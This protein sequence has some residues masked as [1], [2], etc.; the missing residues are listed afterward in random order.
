[1][2][3]TKNDSMKDKSYVFSGYKQRNNVCLVYLE[4]HLQED[5]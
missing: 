2:F 4:C 3:L 5:W 1:M